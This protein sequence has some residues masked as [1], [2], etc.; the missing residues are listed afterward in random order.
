MYLAFA[1]L[2]GEPPAAAAD[3]PQ[4]Q[5]LVGAA[6]EGDR[7]ATRRLYTLHVKQVFRAVRPLCQNEAEAE[8]VVQETFIK[9]LGSLG[10]YRRRGQTRFVSWVL[11]IAMN[12]ARKRLRHHKR[13][14]ATDPATLTASQVGG[15]SP[16]PAGEAMDA[17]LRKQALLAALGELPERERQVVTLRYGAGLSAAEVGRVAGLSEAN[18]RKICQRQRAS[19]LDRI[20]ALLAAPCISEEESH[21]QHQRV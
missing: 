9:V 13:V 1:I 8:D 5:R 10:R 19:L 18:V 17:Q 20:R 2:G 15:E 14:T 16:D 7:E 12:V 4:V 3:E 11:T 6:R 21:E